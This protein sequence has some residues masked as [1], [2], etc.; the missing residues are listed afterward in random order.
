MM[1][2]LASLRANFVIVFG[3]AFLVMFLIKLSGYWLPERYY[4]S[5]STLVAGQQGPF[6]A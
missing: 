3:G 1:G 2:K 4:L 5:F 6:L